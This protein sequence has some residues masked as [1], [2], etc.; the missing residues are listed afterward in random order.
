[1]N[2]R[3]PQFSTAMM[4]AGIVALESTIKFGI[5]GAVG[6]VV[7]ANQPN[8]KI[9][10]KDRCFKFVVGQEFSTPFTFILDLLR[11]NLFWED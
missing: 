3:T 11:N 6:S 2:D 10:F 9:S 1:M 4:H 8:V 7:P 5:G